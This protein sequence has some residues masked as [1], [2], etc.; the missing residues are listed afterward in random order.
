L[1]T[2]VSTPTF[3]PVRFDFRLD[4]ELALPTV[5]AKGYELMNVELTVL[6]P[7]Q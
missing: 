7:H 2:I 3:L 1:E 5:R 6:Q 4:Y